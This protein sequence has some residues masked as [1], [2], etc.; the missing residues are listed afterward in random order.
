MLRLSI[1]LAILFTYLVMIWGGVVRSTDS[2]LACP[3]WPLCYGNFQPPKETAAKLEMGHRTVSGLAGIFVFLTFFLVWFKHK[4]SPKSAKITSLIAL[5]FTFSAALTGMKMKKMET[6][7]FWV[8]A[9][10]YAE[11]YKRAGIPTLPVAKGIKHTKVKTLIYTASLLPLSLL[12]SI[13]GIAG[14]IYFISALILSSLYLILT[15]KFVLSKKP[16]GVFLFFYSVLYIAL[17][18]SVM[19]FDMRR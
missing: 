17:L 1:G 6:P 10:K 2:G 9:I 4:T 5:I 3:D 15:L 13:Y 7:H 11:D 14:H 18:F 8:L 16:N 19:V 12:P